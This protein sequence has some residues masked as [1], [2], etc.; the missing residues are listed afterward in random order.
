MAFPSYRRGNSEPVPLR[1]ICFQPM[2]NVVP[3]Y[4]SVTSDA[5]DVVQDDAMMR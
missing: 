5:G 3:H 2:Y 4:G 1:R